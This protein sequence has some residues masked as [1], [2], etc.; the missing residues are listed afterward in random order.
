MNQPILYIYT[1]QVTKRLEYTLDFVFNNVLRVK[2]ELTTDQE[3]CKISHQPF[4][5]YSN[6]L[7]GTGLWIPSL[8]LLQEEN[9]KAVDLL[10]GS[11]ESLPTIFSTENG[12]IP[13]DLFSAVFYLIT[14]YEEYDSKAL[15][16]HGRYDYRES[17]AYKFDFLQRPL[18]DEWLMRLKEVLHNKYPM[19]EIKTGAYS[20]VSSIDVDHIYRYRAKSKVQMLAKMGLELMKFNFSE[21]K[22]MSK[23]LLYLEKDPYHQFEY[24]D[25][26]H[27]GLSC[28]YILFMHFGPFGKNDRRTI[29]P[30][31]AFYRYLRR[32]NHAHIIGLHPSYKASFDKSEIIKEKVKLEKRLKHPL[33]Y[34]RH[35]YLRI[36]IPE[37]YRTLNEIGFK[38]DFSLGYAAM[39]GFRASTCHAF[40][41]FDI[42]ENEV[43][44]LKIHPTLL[45]DGTM[46]SYLN[47]T[48]EEGLD[49]GKLLVD[50]CRSVNGEFVML[51]HNNSVNNLY[52]WEGWQPSFEKLLAYST[53]HSSDVERQ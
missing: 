38:H 41:F 15:D 53:N 18:V 23:V 12:S 5:N 7:C 48:P 2:Y 51:W 42:E 46:R 6:E 17:A 1:T 25:K 45:M 26:L 19:L 11:W 52:E 49:V 34:T 47:L 28:K 4:I 31:Y 32:Q 30:L 27:N 13:F 40:H 44:K 9:R 16:K 20:S 39:Y 29:Y 36:Q 50:K 10:S 22:R 21:V 8:G 14:R 24:L 3:S 37:T 33:V 35:H 43:L